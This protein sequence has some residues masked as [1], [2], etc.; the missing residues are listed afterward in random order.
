MRQISTQDQL[1]LYI[2]NYLKTKERNSKIKT[3]P[4]SKLANIESMLEMDRDNITEKAQHVDMDEQDKQDLIEDAINQ[5]R[6]YFSS[7]D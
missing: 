3:P 5:I 7:N 2:A 6:I 4:G 1:E